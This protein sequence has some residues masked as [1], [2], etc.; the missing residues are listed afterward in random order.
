MTTT[1]NIEA[2]TITTNS[3]SRPAR[4]YPLGGR[5]RAGEVR[6]G[7]YSAP[8]KMVWRKATPKQAATFVANAV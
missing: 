2:G 4:R 7:T 3:G 8:G 5:G 6:F 1:Q